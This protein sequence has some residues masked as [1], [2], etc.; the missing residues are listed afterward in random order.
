MDMRAEPATANLTF[1]YVL[2]ERNWAVA[3]VGYGAHTVRLDVWHVTDALGVFLR[4]VVQ[5]LEGYEYAWCVWEDEP[6]EHKWI[7]CRNGLAVDIRILRFPTSFSG[8]GAPDEWATTIFEATCPLLKFAIKVRNTV[9]RLADE[10][11]A[12]QYRLRW[13]HDFPQQSFDALRR[14]IQEDRTASDTSL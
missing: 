6:G 9:R 2:E 8:Y 14:L 3:T 13:G 1:T 5:L 12:D 10:V 11:D 4:S 7:F